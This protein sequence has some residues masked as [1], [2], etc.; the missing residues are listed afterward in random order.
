M[1]YNFPAIFIIKLEGGT[2]VKQHSHSRLEIS[3]TLGVNFTYLV[4]SYTLLH[5]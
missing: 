5:N 1:N 2:V 4:I 3:E